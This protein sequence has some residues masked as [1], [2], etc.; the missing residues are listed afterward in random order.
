MVISSDLTDYPIYLHFVTW[1]TLSSQQSWKLSRVSRVH[2]AAFVVVLGCDFVSTVFML[3]TSTEPNPLILTD[4]F[5]PG[6]AVRV[7]KKS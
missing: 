7:R 2:N 3:I 5:L 1:Q 6:W 4:T